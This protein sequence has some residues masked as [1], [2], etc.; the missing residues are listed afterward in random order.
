ML[1]VDPGNCGKTVLLLNLLLTEG[2]IDY[3][4]LIICSTSFHSQPEFK[5]ILQGFELGMTKTEI[6]DIIISNKKFEDVSEL[7]NNREYIPKIHV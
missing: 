6:K 4:N 3:N 2:Y 5:N 7:L 1:I